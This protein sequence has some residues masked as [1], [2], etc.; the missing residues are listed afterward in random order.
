MKNRSF[1]PQTFAIAVALCS[2]AA[3][4]TFWRFVPSGPQ[5]NENSDYLNYY[6]PVA[7]NLAAGKGL[8]TNDGLPAIHYPPGY[9][10][11]LAA[12]FKLTSWFSLSTETANLGLTLISHL[13]AAVFIFLL[14]QKLWADRGAFVAA[15]V[16]ISYP[17]IVWLTKQPNSEIP[18]MAVFYGSV[19]LLWSAYWRRANWQFYV[20]AGMLGGIA[21]LIRPIGLGAMVM[22]GLGLML[23]TRGQNLR[24]R[25]TLVAFL[26]FGN[27][28]AIF[29]WQAWVYARTGRV[30]LLSNNLVPSIRDGLRFAVNLKKYRQAVPVPED[31]RAMM[32]RIDARYNEMASLSGIAKVVGDE[33]SPQPMA[34]I[35]LL[36]IKAA[37][38]WYATDSG[39]REGLI[40][41]FQI[42]YLSLVAVGGWQVWKAGGWARELF[43]GIGLTLIYF[44][45]MTVLTLSILRYLTPIIGLS[46]AL[47]P[48]IWQ[49]VRT[50]TGKERGFR[51]QPLSVDSSPAG[52]GTD[53]AIGVMHITDTL[54]S[55]G[56]ERM[57]VNLVNHLPRERYRVHLC[58]TRRD[59]AL[60]DSVA[61]DVERLRLERRGRFDVAAIYRLR[62]FI[63]DRD[64]RLLHAHNTSLFI[65]LAAAAL[66]PHPAVIWHHHTGRYA[67]EDRSA[68][69]YRLVARRISGVIT[70]NQALAEW[71]ERRLGVAANQV[72]YIPNFVSEA[73]QVETNGQPVQLPGE[74]GKRIICVANIHP[75]KD[76]STLLR[77]MKL[78][79]E[80]VPST[81]L[82]LAGEARDAN[83]LKMLTD[84]MAG[85]GLIN[86]VSL[87]GQQKNIPQILSACDIGVLSSVSEGLPM[88]L[89][90]YGMAGLAV[91]A[92]EVGQCPDVLGDVLDGSGAGIAVPPSQ[93]DKLAEALIRLL[94]SAEL[95]RELGEK[96]RGRVRELYAA[97]AVITDVCRM[98]EEVLNRVSA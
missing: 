2:L 54:D 27:L 41:F 24:L 97:D 57:A 75:D 14:A 32:Q 40:L 48:G 78:V 50:A 34:L 82:L 98:Y 26:L 86:N 5:A 69:I 66:P 47:L 6:E 25:L 68:L 49:R 3:L 43:I 53:S 28:L 88:A 89:L 81:H 21:A 92:T 84:E 36:L 33:A 56:A 10:L 59:G 64:V 61:E 67:M 46:F 72:R 30:V 12:A 62:Q 58:T 65:A 4:L 70:V 22:M 71:T 74:P 23:A 45:G 52:R 76:H 11:L 44:W 80:K 55:G 63:A 90:E 79:I 31:V 9:P 94:E 17:P 95:R 37:R 1:P 77:A 60:A 96:L 42:A 87:L 51:D 73:C 91:A 18:F 7:Q 16:W 93:P 19:F 85:L 35:K 15:L 29:P 13:L 39:R 83:Y 20:L 8:V 38:S